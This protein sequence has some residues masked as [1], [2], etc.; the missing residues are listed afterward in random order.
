MKNFVL[1]YVNILTQWESRI[2][3]SLIS[4][5]IMIYDIYNEIQISSYNL[6]TSFWGY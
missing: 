3:Y 6:Y 2:L 4:G 5:V 1:K